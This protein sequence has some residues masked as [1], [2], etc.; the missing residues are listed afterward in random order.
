MG[1]G[2]KVFYLGIIGF[3][4]FFSCKQKDITPKHKELAVVSKNTKISTSGMVKIPGGI[5]TMG[6]VGAYAEKSEG[7]EI[8]VEVKSFYIDKTEVTNASFSEFVK[9]TSYITV[10]ERP[11]NWE[12]IKKELPPGT[13]KP[14]DSLLLP[15][16]LV[17]TPPTFRVPLNNYGLWWS[18]VTGADWKHPEGPQSTIKGKGN[19]PVVQMAYED[20]QAY[21]SW[22]GKRL[23]TEAE[24]EF[25]SRGGSQNRQFAWGDELVP[26]GSSYLANF[27]QGDFPFNNSEEDGFYGAA[28][29]KSFPKNEFGLYDMIGN[30]WEWTTDMY[31][32]DTKEVLLNKGGKIC[33]NPLGPSNSYDPNDV[34]AKEKRVIKGGSFLCSDQYCSNYRPSSRMASSIDS[35]QNHVGFRCVKDID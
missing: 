15:G 16:S 34:Y 29:I 2:I 11:I 18:W 21:A 7:P 24:W 9:A 35:G 23:P 4:L 8:Q 17:F 5:Y 10:A 12:D 32:P 33:Y 31:R 22:A 1:C 27:F 20:A 14:A 6:S 3:I 28:P 19:F 30:V 26:N 25:A 13:E